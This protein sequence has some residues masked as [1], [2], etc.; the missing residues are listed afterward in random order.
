MECSARSVD[1]FTQGVTTI[2]KKSAPNAP[3]PP[4][5]EKLLSAQ[6]KYNRYSTTSPFASTQWQGTPGSANYG[7]STTLSPELQDILSRTYAAARMGVSDPTMRALPAPVADYGSYTAPDY[8]GDEYQRLERALYDRSAA[9]FEP[10]FARQNREFE[11][12]MYDRGLPVGSEDYDTSYGLISDAQNRARVDAANAATI[13]GRNAYEQDRGFNFNVFD[14]GRNFA[15]LLNQENFAN[16]EAMRAA[17]RGFALN[18]GNLDYSRLAG[19]LG[20]IPNTQGNELDVMGAYDANQ[21]GQLAKY[22]GDLAGNQAMWGGVGDLAG[23][24]M[25][26]AALVGSGGS[27]AGAIP[28]M[29]V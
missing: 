21:A 9:Q 6:A 11:Q 29:A 14:T 8:G 2:S 12:S 23:T 26:A 5:P 20:L 3:K 4:K 10:Q 28:F 18:E 13:A 27:A 17:D 1:G 24:A 22:Q 19:L 16:L 7:I 25:L 15:N